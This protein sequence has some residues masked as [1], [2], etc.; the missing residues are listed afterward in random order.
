MTWENLRMDEPGESRN[1]SRPPAGPPPDWAARQRTMRNLWTLRW[2][3]M[4]L[5]L[6]LAIA[7]IASGA[8]FIGVL[9]A[10][11]AIVRLAMIMV[12]QRRRRDFRQGRGWPPGQ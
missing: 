11:V 7:L 5:S 9:L 8:V 1:G 6:L 3:L 4:G 2:V 12:L 10:G